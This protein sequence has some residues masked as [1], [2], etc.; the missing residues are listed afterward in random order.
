MDIKFDLDK[1]KYSVDEGTWSRAVQLYN[2]GK[3]TCPL[4]R[5]DGYNAVVIGTKSYHVVV[6]AKDFDIADCDCYLGTNDKLCKHMV[7]LAIWMLKRG[8]QLTENESE[9]H[10]EIIFSEKTGELSE[11][12][13]EI[14]KSEISSATKYIKAYNGPS[15]VWFQ[16][17][18]SLSEGCNRL[19]SI[20]SRLPAVVKASEI[21]IS[22]LLKLDKK[23]S[24]GGVDDSDGVVGGFIQESVALLEK[25]ADTN[26]ECINA[27][28]KLINIETCFGWEDPLV[29]MTKK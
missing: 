10:N 17:Q 29:R 24:H 3:V 28:E 23:L 15:R 22:T 25:F 19:S 27:F 16:Y 1:I 8:E 18:D 21:I 6:S 12:D 14:F 13:I 26:P 11:A 4:E 7:A 20:F 5:R 2:S 9:Q